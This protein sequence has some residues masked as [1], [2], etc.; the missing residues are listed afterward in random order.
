MLR[1]V[2]TRLAKIGFMPRMVSNRGFV[3]AGHFRWAGVDDPLLLVSLST[4]CLLPS[5]IIVPFTDVMS[6]TQYGKDLTASGGTRPASPTL[7]S[8]RVQY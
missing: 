6:P 8:T 3:L 5:P 4:G 7:L 2:A 1:S